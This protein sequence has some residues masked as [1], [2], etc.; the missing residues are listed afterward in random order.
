MKHDRLRYVYDSTWKILVGLG[1]FGQTPGPSSVL[2]RRAAAGAA[3]A[4]LCH[5][6]LLRT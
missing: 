5:Y 4:F 2:F 6:Y 3:A 1:D